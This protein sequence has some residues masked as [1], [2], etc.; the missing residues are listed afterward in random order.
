MCINKKLLKQASACA[1]L[2]LF[3][4]INM[5]SLSLVVFSS[6]YYKRRNTIHCVVLVVLIKYLQLISQVVSI[7]L[8]FNFFLYM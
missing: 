1:W 4:R 8:C 3:S 7:N 5:E 6:Q 2:N